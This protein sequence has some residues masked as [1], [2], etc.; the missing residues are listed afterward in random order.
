M[1]TDN[2]QKIY[3]TNHFSFFER[4]LLRKRKEI[5]SLLKEYLNKLDI[6]DILDVGTT[7]DTSNPSS[8][9][10]IKNLGEYK[11]YKSISD[12]KINSSFFSRTL[13]KSITE[14]FTEKEIKEFQSDVVI[15]NATIEHVGNFDNQIKMCSNIIKM[16]KKYFIILTPN[17]YHPFEF[18]TKIPLIHWLPKRV[19]RK[20]LNKIGLSFFAK[21]ENLN[22][23][24]EKDF[25]LIMKNLDQYNFRIKNIKFFFI[26]SNLILIGKKSEK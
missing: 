8:N 15:S 11:I 18:H 2:G 16:V 19:H 17:R 25:K 24:S 26:K 12:Q 22:L 4:I 21:E 7:E 6:F 5:L 14:N 1:N 20:I 10:L 23:L 3:V 13:K 9:Y